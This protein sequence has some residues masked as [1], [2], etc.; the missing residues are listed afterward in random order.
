MLTIQ[1][2]LSQITGTVSVAAACSDKLVMCDG[3]SEQ[4]SGKGKKNQT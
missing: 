4:G 3:A 2:H 1:S